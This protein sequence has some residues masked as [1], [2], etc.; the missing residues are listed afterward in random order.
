ML[1]SMCQFLLNIFIVDSCIE[2]KT[3][4]LYPNNKPWM[5]RDVKKHLKEKH[6]AYIS[7]DRERLRSAQFS[8]KNAVKTA[9]TEY[10]NKIE[11]IFKEGDAKNAWKGI[12]RMSGLEERSGNEEKPESY[13]EELNEFYAIFDA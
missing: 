9:K 11:K 12:K 2:E 10:E 1:I 8:L 3:I 5:N 7:G 6:L 4:V 13:V